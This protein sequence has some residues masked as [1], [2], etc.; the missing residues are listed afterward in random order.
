M[1]ALRITLGCKASTHH[2]LGSILTSTPYH[3]KGWLSRESVVVH[4]LGKARLSSSSSSSS[5]GS[6][7]GLSLSDNRSE[8][9]AD[10]FCCLFW[11]YESRCLTCPL[12]K[13]V[14]DLF[15]DGTLDPS[16]FRKFG[17]RR[18][19]SD[20]RRH[21]DSQRQREDSSVISL[22]STLDWAL[23]VLGFQ[24]SSSSS[25]IDDK[26][27]DGK[28][29]RYPRKRSELKVAFRARAK[30]LHPDTGGDADSFRELVRAY[31]TAMALFRPTL[32]RVKKES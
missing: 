30:L 21:E 20:D 24:A 18:E 4:L 26:S 29:S 12:P 19:W 23:T 13:A 5:G 22:A 14:L 11:G 17:N 16:K 2:L 9:G 28:A 8:V 31:E 7:K 15:D 27:S 1:V 6:G 3:A 10:E 25:L 32:N